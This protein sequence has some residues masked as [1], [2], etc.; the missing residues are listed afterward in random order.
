MKPVKAAHRNEGAKTY[1][2]GIKDLRGGRRPHLGVTKFFPVRLQVELD[3][4]GS[5]GQ[6]NPTDE[7][8]DQ[9]NIREG[10]SEINNLPRR[11]D[12]FPQTKVH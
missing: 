4:L 11:L 2:K 5:A 10:G 12:T 8:N 9:H 7:Q 6:G 3:T 1:P